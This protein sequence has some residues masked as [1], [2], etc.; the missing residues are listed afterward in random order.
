MQFIVNIIFL[1]IGSFMA[2]IFVSGFRACPK[3]RIFSL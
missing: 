1:I 3:L 2:V